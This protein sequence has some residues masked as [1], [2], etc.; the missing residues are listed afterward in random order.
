MHAPVRHSS[1]LAFFAFV[2]GACASAPAPA[3]PPVPAQ[4]A[5]PPAAPAGPAPTAQPREAPA[6]WQLLDPAS[7]GVPGAAIARAREQLTARQPAREVVVAV[8][9]GGVDT[10]HAALRPALWRNAG[11]RAGSRS[12]DDGNGFVDDVWGWNFLGGADGGSVHYDTWEV[13][14]LHALCTRGGATATVTPGPQECG[15]IAEDFQSK[16]MEAELVLANVRNIAEALDA[17]LPLLREAVG[18]SLTA[19]RVGALRPTR[20]DV[21]QARSVYLQLAAAGITPAEVDAAKKEMESRI[22]YKL[23]PD[24]DPRPLVGDDYA[25][26]DQRA[27]GNPDVMGPDAAHGTHVAGIIA[28]VVAAARAE[29]AG[30][31]VRIMAVRAVPDGDEHDKDVANAIRYAVDNGAHVINMSFGKGYSPQKAA[32]DDAVRYADARGVLMVHAAGNDG[33]DLAVEPNYPTPV[34]LDGD[35]ARHWIEVGASAWQGGDSL[36]APFSNY[37]QAEVD[38]FAPGVDIRSAAPGGGFERQSGT[39][40]AA[41]VVAGVAALLMTYYPELTAGD[42]RRILLET[43]TRYTAQPVIRPG[44][45]DRVP[46]GA[47]SATGGIVNAYEAVR[48]AEALRAG[49][50]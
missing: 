49:G 35:R 22:A 48:R 38:L 34:Y 5:P 36:A 7:D 23:N 4:P 20:P 29:G 12:D 8:I 28:S 42:V 26:L 6:D 32:V 24:F 14:R 17:M 15:R 44:G 10:A 33:H 9:D 18:D 16:R 40:M 19:E 3:G 47:L 11:E 13:T 30:P 25:D 37:G 46:F 21:Q 45:V 50:G 39:S 41:P 27:Y 1:W 31:G 2:L 43:A